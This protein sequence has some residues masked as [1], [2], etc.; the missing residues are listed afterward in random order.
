ML[1]LPDMKNELYISF[2]SGSAASLLEDMRK[3][4]K[5]SVGTT[6]QNMCNKMILTVACGRQGEIM[7]YSRRGG[8]NIHYVGGDNGTQQAKGHKCFPV[9]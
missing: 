3:Q 7:A 8:D 1:A 6:D 2:L 5:M 9:V 4:I